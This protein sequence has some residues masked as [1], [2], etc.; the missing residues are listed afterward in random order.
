MSA[1]LVALAYLVASVFFILALKG[2]SSPESARRGNL[3]GMIGMAI[4]VATTLTLT[5]NWI[6]ILGCI[7]VGGLIGAIV[8]QRVQMTA[9]PELVAFMHSL[10]GLAAVFIAIAAVNNPVSFGLPAV[11]PAGSK[12]ELFLGT[13]IGAM[14][15]SGS[16]IAFLKLSG[17]MSGTPIVFSGQHAVNLLLALAMVGCGLWFF[18]SETTNWTAFIAMTA[19]AF[20]L[21][22][23]IIIPIGGADMPVVIS[24]LNSYSGWA[25]AGIGFSLGNPMLIIAGSLVGSSGAILSY[26]MC[27]A[28][29]RPF[30]SVILGG[31]GSDGGTAAVDSGE[32]KTYRSGSADDAAFLMGNADSV[33]IVPGYGLAV[34]RAQH[35]VKELAEKL[36]E[37]GVNVRFAIHPV[38]GR[39]PGHMNVLLAEAEIP[40]EQVQEMEEIN[41]DFSNT[42]VVLVLGANDVV[43][44][45]AY[46][47]GSPIYGMPILDAHKARTV[48]VVK[49]SMAVG[50]AGLDNDLFYM[51]KTMMI[52]GDA[53]KVVESMVKAL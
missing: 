49:R 18:F 34:A 46:V 52:F 35:A 3:F 33:I 37:K 47:S 32:Q 15:W 21:G 45:A 36:H 22:F 23:L 26:I 28:M 9:M 30:L 38:A 6:L 50:Y 48:M 53:K 44:P 4:A 40:Y 24:M 11:L 41:S 20:V 17:R 7:A 27:K 10:V 12:L 14:T 1:N 31:F 43:N 13:F 5:Q 25:A 8:A 19:I 2:L 29:N 42:D 39:M 51:D 16:V